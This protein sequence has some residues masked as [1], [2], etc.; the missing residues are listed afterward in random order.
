MNDPRRLVE[1]GA[2]PFERSLLRS[3]KL[4]VGSHDTRARCVAA[5][6]GAT[7]LG[8]KIATASSAGL[9]VKWVGIGAIVG[10]GA[11]GTVKV[12]GLAL[13]RAEPSR[14]TAVVAR[15]SSAER[16]SDQ[17]ALPV[18]SIE[19]LPPPAIAAS[20][21][22]EPR[23]A[24]CAERTQE[25]PPT[26]ALAPPDDALDRE[27]GL[28]DTARSALARGDHALARRAL[29]RRDREFPRGSLGPEALVIRVEVLVAEGNHAAAEAAASRFLARNPGTAQAKRLRTILGHPSQ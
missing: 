23:A 12:G 1:Q 8:G 29:D 24:P 4:D 28:L 16:G 19:S 10:L 22:A 9:M 18:A 27:V 3:S 6:A 14:G 15:A 26:A 17:A 25:K 21:D 20:S 13:S 2:D 11:A 7:A 5:V